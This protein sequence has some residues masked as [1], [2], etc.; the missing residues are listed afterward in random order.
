MAD[1]NNHKVKVVDLKTHAVKDLAFADLTPP[2]LAVRPPSFPN[3]KT[4]DVPA[5]EATPGN[6]LTLAVTIP[7]PK[8]YKLNEESPMTYLVE[9]P[10]KTGILAPELSLAGEK[11][12]TPKTEFKITVPLAKSPEAGEKF[13]LR[14]SLNTFI[15]SESSSLC[16]IR[17]LIW[18]VP[19][20]FSAT[21]STEPIALTTEEAK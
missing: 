11:I 20:T 9:T 5:V 2:H 15:C 18:N 3:A 19:I 13:D 6:S 21:G 7:L 14:L 1:T 12:K 10:E 4:I 8:G 16:R 17:S